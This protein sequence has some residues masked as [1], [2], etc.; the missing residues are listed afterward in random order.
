MDRGKW[1]YEGLFSYT[2]GIASSGS[3]W[4]FFILEGEAQLIATNKKLRYITNL[5]VRCIGY[6]FVQK[7]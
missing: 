1:I 4:K 3:G 2:N 5:K 6:E 7:Y